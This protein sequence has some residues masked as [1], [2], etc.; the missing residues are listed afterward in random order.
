MRNTTRQLRHIKWSKICII[1]GVASNLSLDIVWKQIETEMII[2]ATTNDTTLIPPS[3]MHLEQYTQ[4]NGIKRYDLWVP[5]S[6]KQL[7]KRIA[8]ATRC[9]LACYIKSKRKSHYSLSPPPIDNNNSNNTGINIDIDAM[10]M[11]PKTRSQK[12]QQQAIIPDNHH[13]TIESWNMSHSKERSIMKTMIN[14]RI[15]RHSVKS[16]PATIIGIIQRKEMI[17]HELLP[18][19][20]IPGY[21]TI[22]ST[23]DNS[24]ALFLHNKAMNRFNIVKNKNVEELQK[25]PYWIF[26]KITLMTLE[27]SGLS[28]SISSFPPP[29][30][31]HHPHPQ[32]QESSLMNGRRKRKRKKQGKRATTKTTTTTIIIGIVHIPLF[33]NNRNNTNT[34]SNINDEQFPLNQSRSQSQEMSL[35]LS[36]LF[37]DLTIQLNRIKTAHPN[38]S[39]IMIG[40]W[41][42]KRKKLFKWISQSIMTNGLFTMRIIDTIMTIENDTTTPLDH[43][44]LDLD[45]NLERNKR[46]KRKRHSSSAT[47]YHNTNHVIMMAPPTTMIDVIKRNQKETRIINIKINL[48]TLGTIVDD[49]NGEAKIMTEERINSKRLFRMMRESREIWRINSHNEWKA[50]YLDDDDDRRNSTRQENMEAELELEGQGGET[51]E[52]TE[53]RELERLLQRFNQKPNPFVMIS[54]NIARRLGL[55]METIINS[56]NTR[57]SLSNRAQRKKHR[58][59]QSRATNPTEAIS[60]DRGASAQ[61]HSLSSSILVY[62][63]NKFFYFWKIMDRKSLWNWINRTIAM[64]NGNGRQSR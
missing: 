28:L 54:F 34:N 15:L 26:V 27:Q 49:H 63:F 45:L 55:T 9:K 53:R 37:Q 4:S 47:I 22:I 24:L 41:N 33:E 10:T 25:S 2:M 48:E 18:L 16:S 5:P 50:I 46:K 21:T 52:T 20:S 43:L 7:A 61:N 39:I 62:P 64:M 44:D 60:S 29:S 1:W 38:T 32:S 30:S 17:N 31:P 12:R 19:P 40:E 36:S 57:S 59:T 6:K 56:T 13:I 11:I 51:T 14:N 8:K 3:L 42:T 58:K 35:S 23:N